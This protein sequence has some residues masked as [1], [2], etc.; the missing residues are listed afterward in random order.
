MHGETTSG[1]LKVTY[2]YPQRKSLLQDIRYR[3]VLITVLFSNLITIQIFLRQLFAIYKPLAFSVFSKKASQKEKCGTQGF[4]YLER[5]PSSYKFLICHLKVQ[6]NDVLV[7]AEYRLKVEH[8]EFEGKQSTSSLCWSSELWLNCRKGKVIVNKAHMNRPLFFPKARREGT[9]AVRC[10]IGIL[11][12]VNV[13]FFQNT[14]ESLSQVC[15][16]DT[17]KPPEIM[18][19]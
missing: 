15:S 6:F 12:I 17:P 4:G 2:S 5:S 9:L 1:D 3:K 19:R 11:Q 14:Q 18:P 7:H 8:N 10:L 13:T 16:Q